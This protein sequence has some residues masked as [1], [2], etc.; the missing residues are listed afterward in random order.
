MFAAAVAT[1]A[2][3]GVPSTMR[4][5]EAVNAP[6]TSPWPCVQVKTAPTPTPSSEQVLIQVK[7]S[8]VNP[9]NVDLVKPTCKDMKPPFGCSRGV[10]GSDVAGTVV[11][12]GSACGDRIKVGDDVWTASAG[13][14][15]EYALATCKQ[16]SVMPKDLS[17]SDA[18]TIPIVGG[19][20]LECLQATGAPWAGPNVTVAITSGSGGTGFMGIQLAKALGAARVVTAASGDGIQMVK[21]LGADLVID[22]KVQEI[23]DALPDNS[24]D[25]VYDNY[26]HPGT[27]DKAMHAIRPGGVFLVLEGG[28]NGTISKH[29]KP[30]VKQIPFGLAD[31]S[32]HEV[33]DTLTKLFN[34]GKIRPHTEAVYSFDEVPAAFTKS[35][36]GTVLGKLSVVPRK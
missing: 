20:S 16:T 10:M 35:L 4:A 25:I 12:V 32:N 30:G 28:L 27:A 9:V 2:A 18:G 13:T 29:P 26:G 1:V 23:F 7:G 34:D 14:Y 15:A 21:E 31:A 3:A 24:V 22:Y 19:T 6:C 5:V 8:S 36:S 33:F 17:F 11:E